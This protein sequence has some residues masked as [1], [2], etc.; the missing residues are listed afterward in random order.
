M[1][2]K[3]AAPVQS[4]CSL[5][6]RLPLHNVL[7]FCRN[8]PAILADFISIPEILLSGTDTFTFL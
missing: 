4:F 2:R 8:L 5:N 3:G 6:P 1:T 7:Y